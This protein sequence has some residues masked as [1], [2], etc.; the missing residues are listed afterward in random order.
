MDAAIIKSLIEKNLPGCA[1][2]I[3]GDDG[4]HFQAMVVSDQFEG[5]NLIKQHRLVYGALEGKIENQ[6]VHALGLKT[7]TV[8]QFEQFRIESGI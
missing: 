5:L 4:V 6:E 8:A 7:M 3:E 2:Y 1:V